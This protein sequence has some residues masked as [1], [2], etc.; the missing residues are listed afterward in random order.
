MILSDL[1]F[2]LVEIQCDDRR[3]AVRS[4]LVRLATDSGREGWGETRIPWRASEL[5]QRRRAVWLRVF[6]RNQGGRSPMNWVSM[7]PGATPLTRIG[8]VRACPH[9]AAMALVMASTA[10]RLME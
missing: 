4:L 6:S 2:F 3:P 1:E 10:A 9:S 7:K 8:S 5:P